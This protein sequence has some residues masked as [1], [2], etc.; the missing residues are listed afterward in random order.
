MGVWKGRTTTEDPALAPRFTRAGMVQ[1]AK[2]RLPEQAMLPETAHQIVMDEVMLDGNA[3]FN[4]ATFVTTW[5]DPEADRLYAATFD[6]NMIDKDEYPQT[7]EIEARCVRMLGDLWHVPEA[8]ESVGT[9]TT[10]SSEGCMLAG[11][12]LKRR[13]QHARRAAGRSTDRPNLVMGANVQV[14]WEKFANY[15]DVEPRY[16]PLEGD[17]LHL[18]A[19]RLLDHVDENTIGVV[20]I[21]GST[22]D[23]SYEPVKEICAALDGYEASSGV[24]VPV[25]V[26]AASGGFVAPFLQAELE[27]D[28]RLDRVVSIQASGHKYGLVYPG[29]GWVLWRDAE[30]LP[31]DLVFHVNYLGGDMPTFALNFSRPGAQVVLQYYQFLRLGREGFRL[32]QQT[33]QDVALHVSRTLAGMPQFDVIAEGRDL[34]V[35]TVALT[36]SVTNYDVFDLSRK[37]RER[38]WLVPAYTMPPK[39]DDLAVLRIV[40]RNGFSHDIAE[41]FLR[42]LRAAVDWLEDLSGP[43]PHEER[44]TT[45]FRH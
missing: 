37:L 4:L 11:L 32:V 18:T 26:D 40:V 15:W 8:A 5:M 39:R 10:G 41:L 3:R 9:S 25:H 34:P 7:A 36:S 12:A 21:L 35:V 29:I 23:G 33:C 38:G 6:K 43:L 22:M 2:N 1:V 45:G 19:D 27:W 31:D 14:V 30:H 17:V 20:A 24:S 42:D 16:V 28:F 44:P 13:W